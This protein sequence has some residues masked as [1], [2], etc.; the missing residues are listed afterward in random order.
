MFVV[1]ENL[2]LDSLEY[3]FTVFGCTWQCNI[4]FFEYLKIFILSSIR[5]YQI[6]QVLSMNIY[7]FFLEK[8]VL[9]SEFRKMV[10]GSVW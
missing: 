8:V 4:Y 1:Y 9:K 5:S 3:Y 6:G 7:L 2:V 10:K